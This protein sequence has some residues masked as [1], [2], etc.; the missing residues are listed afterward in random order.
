MI[1]RFLVRI[2]IADVCILSIQATLLLC[3]PFHPQKNNLISNFLIHLIFTTR[4]D[5]ILFINA[6]LFIF[7]YYIY[8]ITREIDDLTLRLSLLGILN[9]I[10]LYC[11]SWV[12]ML[13]LIATDIRG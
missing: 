7:L 9:F 10:I 12:E 3:H 13:L 11:I 2:I 8:F 6:P 5:I 1:S 4:N